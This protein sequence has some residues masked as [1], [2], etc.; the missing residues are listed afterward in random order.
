MEQDRTATGTIDR[1]GVLTV[2]CALGHTQTVEPVRA[3]DDGI[4]YGSRADYC[5]ACEADPDHE[6]SAALDY[7]IS[8]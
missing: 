2:T 6:G 3:M 7:T 5:D 1:A 8:E 4:W